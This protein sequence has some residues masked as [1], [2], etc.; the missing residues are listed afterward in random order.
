MQIE[1]TD[2]S[3]ELIQPEAHLEE[4]Y[5]ILYDG[6]NEFLSTSARHLDRPGT[7]YLEALKSK[8]D[9]A[10]INLPEDNDQEILKKIMNDANI[11]VINTFAKTYKDIVDTEYL[12]SLYPQE[13]WFIYH[14]FFLNKRQHV[15]ES[16]VSF[17]CENR[18]SLAL[19]IKKSLGKD[20]LLTQIK[21]QLTNFKNTSYLSIIASHQDLFKEFVTNPDGDMFEDIA[22]NANLT[23]QQAEVIKK[24]FGDNTIGKP[25]SVFME[26]VVTHPD[27]WH[28]VSEFRDSIIEKLSIL[29]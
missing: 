18:K 25:F 15:I 29:N 2:L 1:Q 14:F 12:E 7:D 17:V 24:L 23:F 13:I 9:F 4:S 8:V 3:S 6:H 28:I 11:E 16:A 27:Y 26:D 5:E 21:E 22:V 10:S 19:G 20:F